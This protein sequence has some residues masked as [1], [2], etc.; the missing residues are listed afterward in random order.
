MLDR[1]KFENSYR[2]SA[3]YAWSELT[4]QEVRLITLYR[5]MSECN[6]KQVRRITG[7]LAQ[8]FDSD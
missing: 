3:G 4:D 2:E 8:E 7:F 5:E 1:T 6:R